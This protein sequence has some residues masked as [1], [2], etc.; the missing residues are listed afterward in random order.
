MTNKT[1]VNLR[2]P[3]AVIEQLKAEAEKQKRSVNNL[4]EIIIEEYLQKQNSDM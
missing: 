2:L 3:K 4:L 1:Q